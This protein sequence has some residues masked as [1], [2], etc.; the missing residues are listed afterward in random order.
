MNRDQKIAW[1]ES[2]AKRNGLT[3]DLAGEIGF[4]R[5]AVKVANSQ[6]TCPDYGDP[7][8]GDDED[9]WTPPNAYH[10]WQCVA[11]L[12]HGEGPEGELYDW[13]VWFDANGYVAREG[14]A[15]PGT[16]GAMTGQRGV[17]MVKL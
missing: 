8:T 3:L 16:L 5:E 6:G 11:V 9:V 15:T 12:G 17:R 14:A 2:W 10:K 7:M 13:L 4:G 1:M